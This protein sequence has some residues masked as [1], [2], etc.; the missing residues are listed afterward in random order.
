MINKYKMDIVDS[1]RKNV[2]E[3]FLKNKTIKKDDVVIVALS[4]GMDSM[5]LLNVLVS[6]SHIYEFY[7]CCLH[8]NHGI[9]GDEADRDLNFVVK[10]ANDINVKIK[11]VNVNAVNYSKEN[12]K[13]VEEAARILRYEALTWYR[14]EL[15]NSSKVKK[16]IY[17][18]VA[19]HKNDQAETI[20]FNMIRGTGIK[21][22][23]GI[24]KISN[25]IIRPLLDF[26][27]EEIEEY[28]KKLNIPYVV[29]STNEDIKYT[30]N[31]LRL[32][33][34]K[35][36][37]T[38]NSSAV[39]HIVSSIT[40]LQELYEYI[41]KVSDFIYEKI[42]YME[43]ENI[44][45]KNSE[46]KELSHI[47]KVHIIRKVFNNMANKL[48]DISRINIEDI[49]SFSMKEKGGHLDM[50][51]NITI[52]KKKNKLLFIKNKINVSMKNKKKK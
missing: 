27:K 49:I 32:K 48:K 11:T 5:C 26:K 38:I 18:A 6:L 50:P 1:I 29:D 37:E 34:I 3:N 25:F 14:D 45:I 2:E 17:V 12:N 46:F 16:N 44:V 41:E 15:L 24:K 9:R 28:I 7:V 47:I 10:Y 42:S 21:G 51:Y 31:F 39:D 20:L 4:G 19:H 35:D 33:V 22:L 30:R 23:I 36:I 43:D 13:T 8:V 52:D 40:D